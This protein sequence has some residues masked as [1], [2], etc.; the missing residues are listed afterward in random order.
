MT[1]RRS[2]SLSAGRK[3]LERGST[4][5]RL[6][7]ALGRA[8]RELAAETLTAPP[9]TAHVDDLVISSAQAK[10]GV[11]PIRLRLLPA[12]P[13]PGAR[14]VPSR[15]AV[16]PASTAQRAKTQEGC[17]VHGAACGN[18]DPCH[19]IPRSLGGCNDPACTAP[20]CR[21]LHIAYDEGSF[22]LLPYLSLDEQAH[23]VGHVG[24][25]RAMR[26]VTNT[27]LSINERTPF[28]G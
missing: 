12:E 18:A 4:F 25:A 11:T 28:H 13:R 14:F 17:R 9:R 10:D 8:S 26:H 21:E 16:S 22:D 2:R 19:V 7:D 1:L 6:G 24:I 27:P 3:S 23:A 15:S 5:G 20:L